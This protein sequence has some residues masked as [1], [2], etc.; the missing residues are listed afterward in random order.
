[1]RREPSAEWVT[2]ADGLGNE[3]TLPKY[4]SFTPLESVAVNEARL[5]AVRFPNAVQTRVQLEAGAAFLSSRLALVGKGEEEKFVAGFE[6]ARYL[7]DGWEDLG[8]S[9]NAEDLSGACGSRQMLERLTDFL[10]GEARAWAAT[11]ELLTVAGEGALKVASA[12]AEEVGGVVATRPDLKAQ[13][14]YQ[15]FQT[16]GDVPPD[17][18]VPGKAKSGR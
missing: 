16:V 18:E 6:R 5:K 9:M 3:L 13:G 10:E 15:V 17:Y 4:G 7:A 8:W 14:T 1:M 2:L 11:G 12:Y